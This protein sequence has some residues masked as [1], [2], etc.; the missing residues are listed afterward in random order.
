MQYKVTIGARQCGAIGQHNTEHRTFL[1]SA[2]NPQEARDKAIE[3]VYRKYPEL[4]HV[5]IFKCGA[6]NVRHI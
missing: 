2:D 3:R 1:I 5:T 6:E 4:E